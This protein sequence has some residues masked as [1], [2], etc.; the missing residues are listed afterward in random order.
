MSNNKTIKLKNVQVSNP[1]YSPGAFWF[2]L[3]AA[4]IIEIL[5]LLG[6]I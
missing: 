2:S 6:I 1:Q 3:V 4:C 5:I